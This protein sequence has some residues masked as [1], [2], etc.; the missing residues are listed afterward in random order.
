MSEQKTS[1]RYQRLK[2][3]PERWA[4]MLEYQRRWRKE[5]KE[6]QQ[7]TRRRN[8]LNHKD[9]HASYQKEW[10]EK[11]RDRYAA[12][13]AE[14]AARAEV[15]LRR[16]MLARARRE[17]N[18]EEFR[19]RQ[20][21][22]DQKNA[23]AKLARVRNRRAMKRSANGTHSAAD[24]ATLREAQKDRCGYCRTRLRGKGHVDHIKAISRGGSNDRSNLQ[25]LCAPCNVA[26]GAKDAID[27]AQSKG[28]LL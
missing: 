5:N 1:P 28:L 24:I 27:F 2:E 8:Y 4:A 25:L 19:A 13:R 9:A 23:A 14:Y 16:S 18:L 12:Q 6:K 26:K 3:D 17:A 7:A 22:T 15:R 20:R 21:E 10:K 11:N